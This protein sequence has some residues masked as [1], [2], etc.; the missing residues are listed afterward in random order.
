MVPIIYKYS[1]IVIKRYQ[2]FGGEHH[3]KL[4]SSISNWCDENCKA[5]GWRWDRGPWAEIQEEDWAILPIQIS[6]DDSEDAIA[7][8]LAFGF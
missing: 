3:I 2:D 4:Y 8:R 1:Y 5:S 7:F 6:F